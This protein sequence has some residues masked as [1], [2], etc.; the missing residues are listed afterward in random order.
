MKEILLEC[1]KAITKI[2]IK[3]ILVVIAVVSAIL[4]FSPEQ[5]LLRLKVQEI[6]QTNG[7]A[8]GIA[9]IVCTTFL[10]VFFIVW[11]WRRFCS[12]RSF[13][14]HDA[15][16]RLDAMGEWNKALVLQLYETPSHSQRLPLQDANVNVLLAQNVLGKAQLGDLAGFDCV[17]QP[18]V[19]RFLD[20]HP[21]YRESIKPF[22]EPFVIRSR[23]FM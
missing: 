13:S 8:L 6:R 10:F 5:F 17:L 12:W 20:A 21:K 18:W 2:P 1:L 22:D 15:R 11:I 7:M 4:L 16:R 3:V 23:F 14:G 9:L 19:V